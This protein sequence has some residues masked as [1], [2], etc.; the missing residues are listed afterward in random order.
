MNARS[1]HDINDWLCA[2]QQSY[3]LSRPDSRDRTKEK[4]ETSEESTTSRAKCSVHKR[5]HHYLF[6][7]LSCVSEDRFADDEVE[8]DALLLH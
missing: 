1:R 3:H 6:G 8:G 7:L 4:P 5:Q 2:Q